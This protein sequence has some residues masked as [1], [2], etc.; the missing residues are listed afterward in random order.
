MI[1]YRT[2]A[3]QLCSATI[4]TKSLY[5]RKCSRSSHTS[6]QLYIDPISQ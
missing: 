6:Y 1:S 4:L 2:V 3:L 5:K